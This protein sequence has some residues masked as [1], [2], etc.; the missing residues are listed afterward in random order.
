MEGHKFSIWEY[1]P[2]IC[3]GLKRDAF[4]CVR[5][6]VALH[7]PIWQV[8]LCYNVAAAIACR[9][10]TVTYIGCWRSGRVMTVM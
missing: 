7:D 3:P 8:T 1:R 10:D 4:T 6:L 2:L 9:C 5:W